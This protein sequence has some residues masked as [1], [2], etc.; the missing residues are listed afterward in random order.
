MQ[1][2]TDSTGGSGVARVNND[3]LPK[4]SGKTR[5]GFQTLQGISALLMHQGK[6]IGKLVSPDGVTH[7]GGVVID[8]SVKIVEVPPSLPTIPPGANAAQLSKSASTSSATEDAA[9]NAA[10]AKISA[11]LLAKLKP[12]INFT[13]DN[14]TSNNAEATEKSIVKPSIANVG[15]SQSVKIQGIMK[16]EPNAGSKATN[17]VASASNNNTGSKLVS[18]TN[19]NINNSNNGFDSDADSIDDE[20]DLDD[21]RDVGGASIAEESDGSSDNDSFDAL[22]E[23]AEK[24][25]DIYRGPVGPSRSVRITPQGSAKVAIESR[26]SVSEKL[27]S[28][29]NSFPSKPLVSNSST[30]ANDVTAS[31]NRVMFNSSSTPMMSASADLRQS[32]RAQVDTR[33][34][35]NVNSLTGGLLAMMASQAPGAGPRPKGVNKE[36]SKNASS[37]I[38]EQLRMSRMKR[39][40]D[41]DDV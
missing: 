17:P 36:L 28:Q 33:G 26:Q 10:A 4:F 34:P 6:K 38:Q 16:L 37:R 1:P 31:A 2:P 35:T 15:E 5:N 14:A 9:P 8:N 40:M 41:D 11:R 30:T 19:N 27:S 12:K 13:F 7:M 3:L 29:A 21:S 18:N 24:E 23:E 22:A 32:P 25:A 20:D 39:E